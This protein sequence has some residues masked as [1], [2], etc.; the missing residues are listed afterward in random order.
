MKPDHFPGVTQ[1]QGLANKNYPL[2]LL[3]VTI[4]LQLYASLCSSL[5]SAPQVG[6]PEKSDQ[7][8]SLI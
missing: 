7:P 3:A 5:A 4:S 2:M 8:G 6:I 1:V